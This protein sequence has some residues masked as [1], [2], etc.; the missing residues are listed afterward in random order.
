MDYYSYINS[1]VREK[2]RDKNA[3]NWVAIIVEHDLDI[4]TLKDGLVE[5]FETQSFDELFTLETCKDIQRAIEILEA[6]KV[7]KA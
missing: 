6:S 7:E 4:S 5:A 2:F 3:L 1:I